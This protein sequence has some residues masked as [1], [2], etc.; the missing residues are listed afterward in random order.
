MK[1]RILGL[2]AAALIAGSA[3]AQAQ[4]YYG[5]GHPM[6]LHGYRAPHRTP[7]YGWW[8]SHGRWVG[9]WCHPRYRPT[10]HHGHGGWYQACYY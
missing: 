2:A 6:Q 9:E 1:H 5:H 10:W 4:P 3:A 8:G 7:H